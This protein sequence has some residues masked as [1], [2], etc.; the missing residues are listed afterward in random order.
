M[1]ET[2]AIPIWLAVLVFALAA[3]AALDRL[4]MPS[5]RWVLRRR[6][7]RLINDINTRLEI[8]IPSF[9][10]TKREVLIDRLM[11]DPEVQALAE[12]RAAQRNVPREAVMADVRRY[13]REI[14]PAFN[15]YVY[16]RVG[17][18]LAKRVANLLYEVRLGYTDDEGFA[19]IDPKSTVVFVM[20]HRSN[21]DYVLVGFLAAER[22]ALSYAVGEWARVWPLR[23]LIRSMGAYFVRRHSKSPLYRRVLERYVQMATEAGVCQAVYPEGGLTKDGRLRPPKYGLID[24]MVRGF[25]AEA[26][27][28]LVFIPVGINYD[29]VLEDRSLLLALERKG[30]QKE[31]K[32]GMGAALA[33]SMG[34]AAR[35]LGQM[36]RGRWRRFGYA[37]VNFGTPVSMRAY[38]RAEGFDFRE[39]GRE[40][41]AVRVEALVRGLMATVGEVIP[42]LPVSL[43]AATLLAHPDRRFSDLELKAATQR[44][45]ER[46]QAAGAHVYMPPPDQDDPVTAGLDM[47]RLRHLVAEEDGLYAAR[48]GDLPILAYYANAIAHFLEPAPD[49][50]QRAAS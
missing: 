35:N 1:A 34:F 46:L 50:S 25:D 40:Q 13:A 17:Y 29:R 10:L 31:Q 44:M 23:S 19:A 4:L 24:Y 6:L 9:R 15:A 20:N 47:L 7:N 3:W 11:Y 45:I 43:V 5:V 38:V 30:D 28:D 49:A 14:V 16:F 21:M 22:A 27:R 26:E 48:E 42:V 41:R 18:W 12:E 37:C 39:L 2:I 36:A 8:E 32:K 33:T